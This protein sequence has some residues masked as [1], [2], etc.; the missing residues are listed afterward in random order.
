MKIISKEEIIER[1]ENIREVIN[2][3]NIFPNNA[4]EILESLEEKE[5]DLL[6]DLKKSK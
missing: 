5:R 4:D 6:K 2:Y 3:C 1:L